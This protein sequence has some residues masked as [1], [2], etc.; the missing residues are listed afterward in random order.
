MF[1]VF[2]GKVEAERV[3]QY[4]IVFATSAAVTAFA[5]FALWR[6]AVR[7]KLAQPPPRERDVHDVPTPRLGGVA[8]LAG[9]VASFVTAF[10]R[11]EFAQAFQGVEVW[12]L[13]AACLIIGCA[14]VLDDLFD[15][16]WMVKLAAQLVAALV[17]AV[18]GVQVLSMPFG[19]T[20]VVGSPALNLVLTVLLVTLVMNAMNFIDGLD[21]LVAGVALIA[22][23]VFFVYTLLLSARTGQLQQVTL[24]GLIAVALVGACAG[25]LPFNW[26][27]AKMF[28]GDTGSLLVGL[29]MAGSAVLVTGQLSPEALDQQLVLAS[30]IPII[31]PF[32]VLALPL[33]DFGLA[34]L[35]RLRAGRSPFTADRQHLHHRLLDMGHSP[36]QAVI[37]F[38]LGTAVL[39]VAVLLVFVLGVYWVSVL[40]LVGGGL[41]CLLLLAFPVV[42]LRDAA[43]RRG[44]LSWLGR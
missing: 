11:P 35:R 36:V 37:I 5:S 16:D 15:L 18:N 26:H 14:G 13:L 40:V 34:V 24:A 31:L 6:L 30:F 7:F 32:A 27:R 10:F 4:L 17:L 39:S 42:R 19:D 44:L 22:N 20:L 25:F 38:Y 2:P 8:M 21:G 28:M 12:A 29:L 3:L 1:P 41:A 23:A 43:V 33:A 9:I